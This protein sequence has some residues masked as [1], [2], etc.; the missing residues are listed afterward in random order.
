MELAYDTERI[1]LVSLLGQ[2]VGR[3]VHGHVPVVRGEG[4]PEALERELEI[5]KVRA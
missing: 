4:T 5:W 1:L 2:D 3:S